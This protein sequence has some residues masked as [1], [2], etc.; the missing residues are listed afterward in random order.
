MLDHERI[1]Q[2]THAKDGPSL[3]ALIPAHVQ[4]TLEET[5]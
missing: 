1:Y 3:L 5:I 4:T 2:L